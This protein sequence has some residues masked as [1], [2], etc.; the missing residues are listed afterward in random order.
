MTNGSPPSPRYSEIRR[1]PMGGDAYTQI[2]RGV[3]RDSRLR[4]LDMGV[5]G[6]VSTHM[7]G[8][9]T[10]VRQIAMA[11]HDGEDAIK[12]SLRRLERY[13]YLIRGQERNED[14]TMGASWYFLTDLPAQLRDLDI[15]DD[16]LVKA[17]VEDALGKWRAERGL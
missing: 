10:S 8:W 6:H 11:M 15:T 2:H 14:G 17:H 4:G 9:G 1:G 12:T 13:H 16:E 7:E 3:F 5:F